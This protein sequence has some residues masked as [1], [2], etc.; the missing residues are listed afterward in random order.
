MILSATG[1]EVRY[2]HTARSAVRDV[3]IAVGEGELLAVVGPNGSGKTTLLRALLGAVQLEAGR[4]ELLGRPIPAW[5]PRDQARVVGVV[6]QR[7]ESLFPLTV[8]ET[9]ALGR[10]AHLGPLGA[11]GARDRAAVAEAMH[12]A[13]VAELAARRTDTLSGGEWQR[14]RIARAL[15]QEPRLLVLDEPTSSLDVRHEME[16]FELLHRLARQGTATLLVTHHINLAAR[17]AGRLLLLANGEPA[18]SGPP[19]FVLQPDI[20]ARVF[21]WPVAVSPWRDGSPQI[22]PLKPGD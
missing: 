12:R 19:D 22:T 8:V 4:V 10:Y 9:V 15:A 17:Y 13:N 16:V 1:I 18:A 3:D 7:E 6:T 20:L 21:E 14:V 2:P 5:R 11:E